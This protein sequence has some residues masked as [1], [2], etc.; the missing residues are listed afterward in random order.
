MILIFE[1]EMPHYRA[2]V[3]AALAEHLQEELVVCSGKIPASSYHT[4]VDE[5][6]LPFRH[7]VLKTWRLGGEKLYAQAYWQAFATFDRPDA[8]IVRHSVRNLT[9]LPLIATCKSRGIPVVIWGQGYSRNRAFRP[10]KNLFDRLH[11]V[12]IRMADAYVCYTEE[13]RQEI[14]VYA[15]DGK[16]FVATNT[17]DTRSL[18]A[19]RQALEAE[20][21]VNVKQRLGLARRYYLSFV[22]RLQPRKQVPYLI[23]VYR[24]LKSRYQMDIGLLLIGPGDLDYF[25]RQIADA[26]LEDVH[27]P[28]F[29]SLEDAGEYLFASDVLVIP[30]WLGLAVNHAFV[31]GLP[32]VSQRFGKNLL[33]HGPEASYVQHGVSGWFS[34]AGDKESMAKDILHVLENLDEFSANVAA[35]ADRYLRIERMMDGFAAALAYAQ[36]KVLGE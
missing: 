24:L 16:L 28:G 22:G 17:L 25:R 32:V 5:E 31:F 35:Y 13:I 4:A 26:E 18:L 10:K 23:E 7:C 1:Q 19:V 20:G 12:I 36:N 33:G 8:V 34:T 27:L 15:P 29:L 11:L 21:K 9:L 2:P 6:Q 14:A 30:G 3:F